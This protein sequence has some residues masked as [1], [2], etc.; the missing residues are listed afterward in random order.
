ML[1]ESNLK[2][3]MT[4]STNAFKQLS[5]TFTSIF[6]RPHNLVSKIKQ[7]PVKTRKQGIDFYFG[8]RYLAGGDKVRKT[9]Y[10][11]GVC[12][13]YDSFRII[14]NDSVKV[15]IL[16]F[17]IVTSSEGYIIPEAIF[18]WLECGELGVLGL[19]Q[20][21]VHYCPKRYKLS[22]LRN[23]FAKGISKTSYLI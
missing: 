5:L 11:Q 10:E 7:T 21:V 1:E 9:S 13:F 23:A 17:C 4:N 22:K 16:G 2:L 14:L 20:L 19:V 3:T 8:Y 18:H 15:V 6:K 12:R